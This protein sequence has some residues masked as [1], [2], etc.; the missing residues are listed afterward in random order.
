MKVFMLVLC[1]GLEAAWALG[2]V[3]VTGKGETAQAAKLQAVLQAVE[4]CGS[5][6]LREGDWSIKLQR[7]SGHG[8]E[9]SYYIATTTFNCI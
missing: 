1:L 5:E 7:F 4:A 9:A 3:T 6:V 8:W 2:G